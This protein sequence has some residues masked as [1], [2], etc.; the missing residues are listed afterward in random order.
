MGKS[1]P[2]FYQKSIHERS[3]VLDRHS[4]PFR[5]LLDGQV[6]DFDRRS[7]IGKDPAILD[8]LPD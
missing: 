3:P 5:G 8:P 4:P 7:V 6:H 1:I 2:I